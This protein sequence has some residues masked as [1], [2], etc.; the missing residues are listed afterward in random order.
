[1]GRI[2]GPGMVGRRVLLLLLSA[3]RDVRPMPDTRDG[4]SSARVSLFAADQGHDDE[5][6][7][8]MAGC[9]YVDDRIRLQ[10]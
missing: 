2:E 7:D 6:L 3:G 8:A 10:E 4:Q 5:P 1:M 9:E